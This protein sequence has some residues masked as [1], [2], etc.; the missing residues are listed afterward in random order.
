MNSPLILAIDQSTTA[1][2]WCLAYGDQYH[3]SGVYKPRA[4]NVD[5]RLWQI[6]QWVQTTLTV[7]KSQGQPVD[8][9]ALEEPAGHHGR[10]QG[11]MKT[12]RLLGELK[13]FVKAAAFTQGIKPAQIVM[14]YPM[15]VKAMGVHK[16]A[17]P[18]AS[19]LTGKRVTS[20][21]EADA[22]GVWLAALG[23]IFNNAG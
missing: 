10:G 1:T 14:V 16:H 2:G 22:V 17:L 12:T 9:L 18:T 21:D 20:G 5:A 6:F 4:R 15:Q 8:F 23:L 19:A 7:V 3:S 13:G 11:N